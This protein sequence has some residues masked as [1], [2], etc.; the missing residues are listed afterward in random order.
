MAEFAALPLFTDSWIADTAH[1]TRHERGLYF[2]L[3]VLMWR[4]PGC[5]VPQDIDWTMRRLRCDET[6]RAMLVSIFDEF[7][8]CDGNWRTQ[9]R[10]QKEFEYV[11]LHS[12]KQSDSAKAR[13]NKEKNNATAYAKPMPEHDSRHASGNA[14]TPT[15]TPT[16]NILPRAEQI[17]GSHAVPRSPEIDWGELET[18]LRQ[19]AGWES[20]PHP[21]LAIVGP[22]VSLLESGYSLE[23]DIL[24]VIKARAPRASAKGWSYF[25]D[26]I[27]DAHAKRMEAR[28]P[29]GKGP[30]PK[31]VSPERLAELKAKHPTVK[32]DG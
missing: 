14:P 26:A 29:P 22:I 3:L 11:R 4:T 19:A 18:K 20:Q 32:W 25:V 9:K 8:T 5:R 17:N 21:N 30:G 10:L 28:A 16:P 23:W 1:L 27:K 31:R 15:P 12:R 24:P 13:W 6:E 2:D 7:C